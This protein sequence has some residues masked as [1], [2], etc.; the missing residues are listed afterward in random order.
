M[1]AAVI[2]NPVV[3]T[4]HREPLRDEL[5]RRVGEVTWLETTPEDPGVG[6]TRQAIEWGADVVVVCG[7]D[8]T[9]RA[10]AEGLQ[11]SDVPLAIVPAGTG[12][13]LARNLELPTDPV[14]VVDAIVDG[15]RTTIDVGAVDG[16]TFTV[17]AGAGLD[18]VIMTETSTESKARLG[19]L[20]YVVEGVNHLFDD[21]VP[22]VIE[23]DSGERVEAEWVTILVGNLGRLP[24]G[25]DLF[26]DSHPGDAR[27]D[28]IA[29]AS[30]SLAET[31]A[32]G[33]SAIAGGERRNLLR[34][35]SEGFM[36][37]FARPTIYELDGE[38][39]EET[40]RLRFE[41]PPGRLTLCT[42]R[43]AGR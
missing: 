32:G 38:P 23:T 18:A 30:G 24:G 2:C 6:A 29:L 37:E 28:L 35:Q 15:D 41:V 10:C 11:G 36:I 31:V 8:G 9:V 19:V 22:A 14:A 4:D 5:S 13:L 39:R 3:C 7:G 25:V 20:S 17:M 42:K 1:R 27:L 26:P 34:R 16:E 33:F 21:P 40:K 43:M 12:N